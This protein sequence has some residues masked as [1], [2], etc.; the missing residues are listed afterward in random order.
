MNTHACRISRDYSELKELIANWTTV[1]SKLLVY[2]HPADEEVKKTHC[3][4]LMEGCRIGQ[5]GLRK[6]VKTI[7]QLYGNDDWSFVQKE[8]DGQVERYIIYM[9]KG[10]L[11]PVYNVGYCPVYLE[12][13]RKVGDPGRKLPQRS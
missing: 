7:I 5:E 11:D 9:T 2:Q 4:F 1:C 13:C 12:E 6:R 3:H 10:H 8:Y